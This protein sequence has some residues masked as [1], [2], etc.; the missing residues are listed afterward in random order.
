MSLRIR[1][2]L[3]CAVFAFAACSDD[4]NNTT[5]TADGGAKLDVTKTKDVG[6]VVDQEI[7]P[8]AEETIPDAGTTPKPDT[9]AKTDTTI[10]ACTAES[11]GKPCTKSTIGTDCGEGGV[12]LYNT[13]TGEGVCTCECTPD[14]SSTTDKN[15]DTCPGNPANV[16]GALT[17]SS[18][19]A[20][21][22]F[23]ICDPKIGANDCGTSMYCNYYDAIRAKITGKGV[24][25]RDPNS[26][27]EDIDCGAESST[28]CKTDATGCPEGEGCCP[29]G[30][31]CFALEEDSTDGLCYYSGVC[32]KTSGYCKDRGTVEGSFTADVKIGA[33]CTN[34]TQ[35][36]K[37]QA[38]F[39]QDDTSQ[40]KKAEGED[41]TYNW[42]CC[43]QRCES[44]KC[45]KG[46]CP[47]V[48]RNGYCT[49]FGCEYGT[50]LTP[51]ACG[52]DAYCNA[53]YTTYDGYIFAGICQKKCD[54][55]K[56]E[57]CRGQQA[58]DPKDVFGDYECRNWDFGTKGKY[59]DGPTCDFGNVYN[60]ATLKST[61]NLTCADFGN[62]GNTTNM[63][64]QTLAG[65][66]GASEEDPLGYCLDDTASGDKPAN[67]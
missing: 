24:C 34:D 48:R 38:C 2:L 35:C 15:E 27:E 49:I 65:V 44:K 5:T 51:K 45:T 54:M 41:C 32:D 3:I 43:S 11:I 4:D 56:P 66:A 62:E 36:D 59:A 57:D 52:D 60:C 21:L 9:V 37:N 7:I 64:C 14:D 42:E 61:F 26:C 8:D 63:K 55:T 12:C 53:F 28:T 40:E 58:T 23:K 33:P 22:C 19:T 1:S 30:Q 67:D 25:S 17:L 47:V 18:G 6:E 10:P 31:T 29:T 39:I 20:N 16:C 13:T 46:G 50:T